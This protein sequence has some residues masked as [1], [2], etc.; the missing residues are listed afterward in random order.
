MRCLTTPAFLLEPPV[1]EML[2]G[3]ALIATSLIAVRLAEWLGLV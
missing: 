3:L 2:F 1:S